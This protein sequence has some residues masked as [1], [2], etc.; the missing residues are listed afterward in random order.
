MNRTLLILLLIGLTVP[1]FS[2]QTIK[3]TVVTM[4]GEPLPGSSVFLSNTSFGTIS[5]K[6]GYFELTNIPA[7]RY[8]LIASSIG[9]E[10]NVY[11]FSAEQLPLLVKI[12][13]MV[14][15]KELQNV[16]VEPFVEEGWDK[17]GATFMR[18]FIGSTPN[19]KSCRIKNQKAIHFRY[20]KKSK[21]IT[22]YSDEPIVIEN[23]ALGYI[24]NYQLEEFEIDF[25]KG[26]ATYAGY[27]YFEEIDKNR[28]SIRQRWRTARE[29]AYYGSVMHFMRC[30]YRDS[31][32]QNNY[33]VHRMVRIP[34]AEKERIKR[35]YAAATKVTFDSVTKRTAVNMN[36][37]QM[38]K[39]SQDY[40]QRVLNQKDYKEIYGTGTLTADSLLT[41]TEGSE[42]LMFFTDYL[43]V[44]YKAEPE[45]KE[46]ITYW[47]ENRSPTFQRSYLMLTGNR[48]ISVDISGSYYPPQELFSMAY[49]AW[50][51]KNAD[52]LPQ[53]YE[54]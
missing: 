26:S 48:A 35:I 28:N 21:R 23:R 10:T 11:S 15:V 25:T 16:T 46:Y 30:L 41:K 18:D 42:K 6:N 22:A 51:E 50:S 9:Y 45:D 44:T 20:Y 36:F 39:D 3:G 17:W 1:V 53:D 40:Y 13:M 38:A 5:D 14:K 4:N 2:Q 24:I 34:N 19:A 33:E 43:Y 54:P 37:D 7:G 12:Q 8:D 49:W 31:L 29:K 32:F 27:P 52:L 47:S